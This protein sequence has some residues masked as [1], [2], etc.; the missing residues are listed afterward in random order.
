MANTNCL[1]PQCAV[2]VRLLRVYFPGVKMTDNVDAVGG[3]DYS[4]LSIPVSDLPKTN[5][6]FYIDYDTDGNRV[7]CAIKTT[8]APLTGTFAAV[9]VIAIPIPTID[10]VGGRP[11]DRYPH[12]P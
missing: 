10:F 12:K 2:C 9:T 5:P 7:L 4:A 3:G 11:N 6:Q 8:A 1:D